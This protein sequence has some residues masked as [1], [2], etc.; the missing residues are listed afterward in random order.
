MATSKHYLN[1]L[2]NALAERNK[3]EDSVQSQKL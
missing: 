3:F 1:Q 2:K